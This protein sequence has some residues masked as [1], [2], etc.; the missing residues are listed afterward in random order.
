MFVSSLF[1]GFNLCQIIEKFKLKKRID[2]L[3]DLEDLEHN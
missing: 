3:T 2:E 1:F